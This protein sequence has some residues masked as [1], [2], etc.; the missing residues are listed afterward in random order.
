MA[1]LVTGHG[2][3]LV[4]RGIL[5]RDVGD[6]DPRRAS[7]SAGIGREVVRLTRAVEHVDLVRRNARPRRHRH[8]GTAHRPRRHGLVMIEQGLDENRCKQHREGKH[9]GGQRSGPDPPAL[10]GAPHQ[11]VEADHEHGA[12]NRGDHSRQRKLNEEVAKRLTRYGHSSSRATS[13]DTVST[14]ASAAPTAGRRPKRPGR[15]TGFAAVRQ[16]SRRADPAS[17]TERSTR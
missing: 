7:N 6:R 17:G 2:A 12:D 16:T 13:S 4:E 9:D 5:E 1:D 11:P 8:H 14:A 3:N 15:R 10:S